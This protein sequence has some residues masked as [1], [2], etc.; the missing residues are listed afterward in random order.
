MEEPVVG[1]AAQRYAVDGIPLPVF[2]ARVVWVALRLALAA[3]LM[4]HGTRFFYQGF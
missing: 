1:P 2:V 3:C 4:Q